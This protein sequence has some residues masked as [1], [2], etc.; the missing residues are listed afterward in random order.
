MAEEHEGLQPEI[1][2][3]VK[4][5]GDMR[6]VGKHGRAVQLANK[7]LEKNPDPR[8][9]NVL[10]NFKADSL[11]RVGRRVR[12]QEMIAEARGYFIEVLQRD[13][14]DYVAKKGLEE[15]DFMR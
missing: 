6:E 12:S 1:A 14:N 5:I 13:P 4:R 11:Y 3:Y 2:M 7:A 9:L 8:L 15:I 10:L